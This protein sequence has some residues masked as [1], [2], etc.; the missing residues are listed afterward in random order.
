MRI[1]WTKKSR[2]RFYEIDAH[3]STEYGEQSSVKFRNKV[4]DFLELLERF[5]KLGTLEVIEKNIYGFQITK[6]TRIFYRINKDHI[7]LLTF[8][9]DR[10]NPEKKPK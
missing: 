5:P 7:S 3:I 6:Q 1:F 4:F 8:F 10:Q 9:D 2:S